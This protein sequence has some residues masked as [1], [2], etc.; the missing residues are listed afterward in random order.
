M[1]RGDIIC[2]RNYITLR[3]IVL[4]SPN[5]S[6]VVDIPPRHILLVYVCIGVAIKKLL[7]YHS[8]NQLGK[9]YSS[10]SSIKCFESIWAWLELFDRL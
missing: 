3:T 4:Q 6:H 2:I 7:P 5:P 1:H 10:I 9:M 8:T